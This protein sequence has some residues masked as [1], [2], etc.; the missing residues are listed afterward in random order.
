MIFVSAN[1]V[2]FFVRIQMIRKCRGALNVAV[3]TIANVDAIRCAGSSEAENPAVDN[4]HY[5]LRL[6]L[7]ILS[8]ELKTSILHTK[9][10]MIHLT[11]TS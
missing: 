11:F 4:L 9:F 5:L 1:K 10:F 2:F 7:L 6:D 8:L 3:V